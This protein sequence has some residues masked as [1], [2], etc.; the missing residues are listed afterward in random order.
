M[1]RMLRERHRRTMAFVTLKV[2]SLK[3]LPCDACICEATEGKCQVGDK[4]TVREKARVCQLFA[5]KLWHFATAERRHYENRSCGLSRGVCSLPQNVASPHWSGARQGSKHEQ[6]QRLLRA[7]N[8][9]P[10]RSGRPTPCLP[11]ERFRSC[12]NSRSRFLRRRLTTNEK[13]HRLPPPPPDQLLSRPKQLSVFF[14]ETFTAATRWQRLAQR[15]AWTERVPWNNLWLSDIGGSYFQSV[16]AVRA[17]RDD[18]SLVLSLR[19]R[20]HEVV[21]ARTRGTSALYQRGNT[22]F[23]QSNQSRR[24][25]QQ[26]WALAATVAVNRIDSVRYRYK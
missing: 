24:L 9:P 3:W 12:L 26:M 21:P 5:W 15:R 16:F 25:Q 13:Q 14:A 1:Q 10:R 18:F 11:T 6:G 17:S 23:T 2:V 20:D 7:N 19:S 22:A 4:K 8:V